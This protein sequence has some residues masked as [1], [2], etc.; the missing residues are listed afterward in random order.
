MS[1]APQSQESGHQGPISTP[2]QLIAAVLAAF[3][4]PVA[5]IVLLVSY[6]SSANKSAAGSDALSPQAVSQRIMPVGSVEIKLASANAGPRSGE[7]VYKGSCV[8]C[9]G[10]GMLGAPKFGDAAA[11]GPRIGQ[12]E[13]KLLEHALKGFNAMP[14]QGGGDF[15]D[16]EVHRAMVYMANN[17]GAKFAEPAAPAAS[18]SA[19]AASAP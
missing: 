12:G 1:Q 9:H 7:E 17:G 2:Q 19:E 11:W 15:S 16:L 18:G 14:P 8:N 5:I 4:V 10:A 13:A 3:V 6:V